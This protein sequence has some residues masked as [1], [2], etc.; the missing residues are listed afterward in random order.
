[1]K[2]GFGHEPLKCNARERMAL[3]DAPYKSPR[4]FPCRPMILAGLFVIGVLFGVEF[5]Q[6]LSVGAEIFV[7]AQEF[8]NLGGDLLVFFE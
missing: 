4:P 5:F 7:A 2:K 1:M 6:P 3:T 8:P